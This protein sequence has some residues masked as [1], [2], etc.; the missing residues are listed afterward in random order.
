MAGAFQGNAFQNNAFQ[1]DG[2]V[3]EAGGRRRYIEKK[4]LD[5]RFKEQKERGFSRKYYDNLIAAQRA[6][7]EAE[8]RAADLYQAEQRETAIRAA[9]EAADALAEAEASQAIAAREIAAVRKHALALAGAMT[10]KA[11]LDESAKLTEYAIAL[12]MHLAMLGDEDEAITLLMM[13]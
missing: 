11:V 5:R 6:Q 4:E 7:A 9:Q 2:G 8:I 1:T 12:R 3:G 10:V 13:H